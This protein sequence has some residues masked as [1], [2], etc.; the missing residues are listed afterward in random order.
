MN[1]I[2]WRRALL[3]PSKVDRVCYEDTEGRLWSCDVDEGTREE[4]AS[5][6]LC[7]YRRDDADRVHL[8]QDDRRLG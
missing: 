7:G 3:D 5:C 8:Y 6:P 1:H 4:V 2:C